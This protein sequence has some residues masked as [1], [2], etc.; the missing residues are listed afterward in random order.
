MKKISL[1]AAIIAVLL[2]ATSAFNSPKQTE[3]Y[4]RTGNDP[5]TGEP[6]LMLLDDENFECVGSTLVCKYDE[7]REPIE[8]FEG[9]YQHK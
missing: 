5:I 4:G 9:T 6:I 3:T 2:V 7:N 1:S 8:A